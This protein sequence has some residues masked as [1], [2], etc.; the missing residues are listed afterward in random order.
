VQQRHGRTQCVTQERAA[1]CAAAV[2]KR[3]ARV[4]MRRDRH[5]ARCSYSQARAC[6]EQVT[7]ERPAPVRTSGPHF[8][9]HSSTVRGAH[10]R[11]R[12]SS[13]AVV[14]GSCGWVASSPF[15]P[16]SCWRAEVWGAHTQ[17]RTSS[18]MDRAADALTRVGGLVQGARCTHPGRSQR[19]GTTTSEVALQ[20]PWP[21]PAGRHN[22]L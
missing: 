2:D 11:A 9:A 19:A 6:V 4:E 22:Y 3:R 8:V 7:Q 21:K 15:E 17:A 10:M 14:A 20:P 12:E 16:N 5:R 13:P 1:L 18:R